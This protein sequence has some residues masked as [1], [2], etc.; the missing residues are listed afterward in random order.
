MA[1]NP[2][3]SYGFE[4]DSTSSSSKKRANPYTS[5]GFGNDWA[6][7]TGTDISANAQPDT[8][9][10]SVTDR[11]LGIGK[12]V[13]DFGKAVAKGAS[14]KYSDV[15]AGLAETI[16]SVTGTSDKITKNF[17]EELDNASQGLIQ[18]NQKLKGNL[19]QEERKRWEKVAEL[20][21]QRIREAQSQ[22][23]ERNKEIMDRTNPRQAAGDIAGIG[24]DVL[25]AGTYGVGAQG[26]RTGL[27]L[28][29]A[30][31]A[32][33]QTGRLAAEG[34]ITGSVFG[35]AG[36]AAEQF[37]QG[38]VSLSN[39]LRNVALGGALGAG[40]GAVEGLR[41]TRS[42]DRA[43]TASEKANEASQRALRDSVD[44][45][46]NRMVDQANAEDAFNATKPQTTNLLPS[47]VDTLQKRLN[48]IDSHLEGLRTG[49]T[50]PNLYD[51]TG[52][53][54]GLPGEPAGNA[55]LTKSG[56][57]DKRGAGKR[58]GTFAND[59]PE[60]R[61]DSSFTAEQSRALIRER[62]DL[63][64]KINYLNNPTPTV[65]GEEDVASTM[66]KNEPT[67]PPGKIA[68]EA[69]KEV[70]QP[71]AFAIPEGQ[72]KEP[73]KIKK[74]F[75]STRG[76]LST[77]GP[78]GKQLANGIEAARDVSERAQA[79]FL[80]QVPSVLKLSKKDFTGFVDALESLSK[81]EALP[82]V[83]TDVQRAIGEWQRVIPTV[84]QAA[85][86][87]GVDVGDLGENYF[88]HN[89]A[90]L[91]Q[92]KSGFT[93]AVDHLVR[94]GQADNT[95][96]AT[97]KLRFLQSRYK[98][99]FGHFENSRTL[100]LPEFDKTKD[101][102]VS[103]VK[104]A[105]DRVAHAEQF[106]A[107][108]EKASEL[109]D[110]IGKKGGGTVKERA[111]KN[112]MIAVGNYNWDS[113]VLEGFSQGMRSFN[114]LRLLGLSSVLNLGQSTNVATVS[115][116]WNTASAPFKLLSKN[117]RAYIKETGTILDSVMSSIREQ[118]G[119]TGKPA[120]TRLGKA[121]QMVT[122]K[123]TAPF[124][125][126]VEKFNRS[127]ASEAGKSYA[128]QLAKKAANGNTKAEQVLRDKLG[129][130]GDIGNTLTRDQQIQAS[131]AMVKITQFKVDPQDLPGWV[132][133]PGGKLV[134]Q[135]RTFGYKQTSFIYD[136]VVKEFFKGNP[137]PLVRFLAVGV[138]IGFGTGYV[139]G[140]LSGQNESD[141][142]GVSG[143]QDKSPAGDIIEALQNVGGFG[144]L[145][146]VGFL[147]SKIGN[148]RFP[149]YVASSLGGPTAG[150][151]AETTINV[152]KLAQ[153]QPEALGREGLKDIPV[154]GRYLSN[155]ALPYKVNVSDAQKEFVQ[156]SNNPQ[157][158]ADFFQSLD[159]LPSKKQGKNGV[160]TKINNAVKDG[161]FE[162][163]QRLADTHN[164]AVDDKIR[165]LESQSG[166]LP[167][168]VLQYIQRSYR[169]DYNYYV[170]NRKRIQAQK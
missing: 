12:K 92:T 134:S 109:I 59:T 124:F 153:G 22:A 70:K 94:S 87:A 60:S 118:S 166:P 105:F 125:N 51:E 99:S 88:P 131:R 128:N 54:T 157:E 5:Y 104:G 39:T 46:A 107:N 127:V 45:S 154:A 162:R 31:G 14:R 100:D 38:D 69:P 89:Y 149:Q 113:P 93:K 139:R 141:I 111:L 84:R 86:R 142:K 27:L 62:K 66:L 17:Q 9:S 43:F 24:L 53:L 28:R 160:S 170:K 71:R 35:G 1:K 163:A 41:A 18:A 108:G 26:A 161:N 21:T 151:A 130:K 16:A 120:T 40:G 10:Q 158:Y 57:I 145:S 119:L 20:N 122:N 169:V 11:L 56:E 83:S 152:N 103:Y 4:G 8:P 80:T 34:A 97:N 164:A 144:M 114:R 48:E 168:D 19:N 138:P 78:E 116:L 165:Q 68:P 33:G 63:E 7:Y 49:K 115:G 135:F 77:Y 72:L 44:P 102:L 117:E 25:S 15:G 96:D 81:G 65:T 147:G 155:M 132:D 106:G 55:K 140:K 36:S 42:A 137:K 159:S 95:I 90:S 136:Q 47:G 32:A 74:I 29:G 76:E 146:D 121:G 123:A 150:L 61:A 148:E 37:G 143:K 58:V 30:T 73:G 23:G 98:T 101:A 167:D 156:S 79:S 67:P 91:L 50:D 85:E 2:Y 52:N 133:S 6:D 64:Q 110:A 13:G 3:T 112:Y 75:Q 129:I 82:N 126:T